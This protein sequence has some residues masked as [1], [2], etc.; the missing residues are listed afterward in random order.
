MIVLSIA[1]VSF[2]SIRWYSNRS[3]L[4]TC[5]QR[6]GVRDIERKKDR[7]HIVRV[8]TGI[9]LLNDVI[10]PQSFGNVPFKTLS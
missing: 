8:L 10:I 6:R 2:Q 9:H 5:R 7:L 1:V 3:F 4:G